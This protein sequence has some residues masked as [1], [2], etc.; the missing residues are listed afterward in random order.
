MEQF[1]LSARMKPAVTLTHDDLAAISVLL[2]KPVTTKEELLVA[3]TVQNTVTVEG[4]PITL[5]PR[6]LQRLKSRC[7][8]K[9]NF[10]RWLAETVTRQLHDYC[11]W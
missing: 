7:L 6:L 4:V 5:E 8:D 2:M 9:P 3:I 11:G 10:P 1:K